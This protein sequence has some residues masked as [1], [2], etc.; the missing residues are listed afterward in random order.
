MSLVDAKLLQDLAS[1]VNVR[2]AGGTANPMN[3]DYL[4]VGQHE[5]KNKYRKEPMFAGGP[6]PI[7]FFDDGYWKVN[8]ED[9]TTDCIY[10]VR[11]DPESDVLPENNWTTDI[12]EWL[13]AP[14]VIDEWLKRFEAVHTFRR[15]T[16]D[17][18]EEHV[19]KIIPRLTDVKDLV[20]REV[21][22]VLSHLKQT[23][24]QTQADLLTQRLTE[25]SKE[26][27][28]EAAVI[29]L[30]KLEPAVLA[31]HA[32]TISGRLKDDS[33]WVRF[34]SLDALGKL[35]KTLLG[36]YE[37][38]LDKLAHDDDYL[39]VREKALQISVGYKHWYREKLK[40]AGEKD[41]EAPS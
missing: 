20:R 33:S 11:P 25:D 3:G 32:G 5:N 8:K 6:S 4:F 36:E 9:D 15:L 26:A 38:A 22:V 35:D 24:L 18:L 14:R 39:P 29:G 28:R 31:R 21:V 7:I 23:A 37:E 13:P 12:K 30:G 27:V 1:Y 41:P 2:G 40:A 19:D 10:F 17:E 16:A 34:W